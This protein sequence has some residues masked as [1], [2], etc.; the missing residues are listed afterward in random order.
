MNNL[1]F[2]EKKLDEFKERNNNLF[3]SSDLRVLFPT[4]SDIAFRS[5]LFRMC[6]NKIIKKVIKNIY[7]YK[8][9][10]DWNIL[11]QIANKLRDN[12]FNYLSLESVLINEGL[13]S[14]Q[15]LQWITVMTTGR[16]N[17]IHCG[18]YGTIEF[19]KTTRVNSVS[20]HLHYDKQLQFWVADI[21][22]AKEDMKHTRRTLELVENDNI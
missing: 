17:K 3:F 12:H 22:L 8:E 2:V 15:A 13:I 9:K 7:I 20:E 1:R 19:I 10:N 6:K 18:E 14:Q 5:R 4:I 16:S 21:D 11:Y